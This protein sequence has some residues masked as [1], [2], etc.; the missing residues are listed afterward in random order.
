MLSPLLLRHRCLLSLFL[1]K[2][3]SRT[4]PGDRAAANGFDRRHLRKDEARL[5]YEADYQASPDMRVPG[6]WRMRAGGIPVPPPP[7]GADRRAEIARIQSGLPQSSCN[8]SR[9]APDSNA[10]WTAYFDR[11][12]ANQ[13]D[14]TTGSNPASATTPRGAANGG[15]SQA[16]P[17]RPSSSTSRALTRRG[18]SIHRHPPSPVAAAAPGRRGG[19]RRRPPCRSAPAPAPPDHQRSSPSSRSCRRR[20]WGSANYAGI[21]IN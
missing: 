16:A 14:A 17:W 21:F 2:K 9:Y 6:S 18:T 15:A 8:L 12:H 11:R 13:L 3:D 4:L 19:W 5:L 20:R 7:T 10:L 1:H